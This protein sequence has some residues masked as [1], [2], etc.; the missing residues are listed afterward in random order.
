MKVKLKPLSKEEFKKRYNPLPLNARLDL[1]Q[2]K[3]SINNEIGRIA[4]SVKD[5]NES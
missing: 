5:K 3:V 4:K 1:L 2:D